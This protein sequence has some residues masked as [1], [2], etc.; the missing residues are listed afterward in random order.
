MIDDLHPIA[1]V[2]EQDQAGDADERQE[3][4]A[5]RS[6][7][8]RT[9]R[10]KVSKAAGFQEHEVLVG[11]HVASLRGRGISTSGYDAMR[12]GRRVSRST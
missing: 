12:P 1:D 7:P 5:F 11:Q 9:S 10:W 4:V 2:P 8:R 3:T 6:H